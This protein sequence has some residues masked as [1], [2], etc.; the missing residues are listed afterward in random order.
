MAPQAGSP[1]PGLPIVF[2]TCTYVIARV[3]SGAAGVRHVAVMAAVWMVESDVRGGC[4]VWW[5]VGHPPLPAHPHSH[6]PYSYT[7]HSVKTPQ[8][9]PP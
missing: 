9:P 3:K 1:P 6:I 5:V 8:A 2:H 7:L 4:V